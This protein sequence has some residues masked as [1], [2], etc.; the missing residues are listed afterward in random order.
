MVKRRQTSSTPTITLCKK[1]CLSDD[2]CQA[3]EPQEGLVN[4]SEEKI[5]DSE[6]DDYEDE[7]GDEDE[8]ED[9]NF[10]MDEELE[11]LKE[12]DPEAHAVLQ[13]VKVEIART[14]PDIYM[15]LKT[16]MRLE[17]RAKLCQFYEIYHMQV[18]NTNEWLEAR[19]RYNDMFKEYVAGYK[20][21]CKYS[22]EDIRRM[23]DE[24]KQFTGFDAQLALKYKILN[25]ETSK[26]NKEIIYRRYEELLSLSSTDDEYNKLKH[27][28]K[29]A[30][31][32]PHDRIRRLEIDNPT[33]FIQKAKQRLDTELYGMD[34]VKEQILLFLSGK[35]LNP[36]M[37]RSNL[38]LV[39][40][41]GCG[42]THIARLIASIM[43]WGF[44]QISLGGTDRAEFLKGHEYTYVGAQPG[45]IAKRM[46]E[47]GHKNGV[48]FFDEF[49]KIADSPEIRATML[50]LID[51]S[52]NKE[53][54]DNFLSP[55][56]IDLSHIWYVSSM[57]K[58]PDDAALADRWWVIQLQGYS[59]TD[60]V[61]IIEEYLIPRALKNA[62]LVDNSVA[63]SSRAAKHL[64]N[65]VCKPQD[66]G[67]RTL[68][69][70]IGDLI[71]KVS[72]IITHQ[73]TQGKLPFRTSFDIQSPLRFPVLLDE[74]LIDKL[75]ENVELTE[76]VQMMYI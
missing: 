15:L 46:K 35:I 22:K 30:T 51:P 72:F 9:G 14:E 58:I 2:D 65:G 26:E 17:D 66:K 6:S 61:H 48:I 64:I 36:S 50:H 45:E 55:L 69:N 7:E 43:D 23:E 70:H 5:E 20:Q 47:M 52:Q 57:N 32:I 63:L 19:N 75:V 42:K 28:L 37:R 71:N 12:R 68:E 4:S 24:E 33:F 13:D 74:A 56:T 31:S 21:H 18:P 38:A 11:K 67:V 25:L 29:W 16:P 10:N 76:A 27:W 62:G 39:G 60:K 1:R 53:F 3:T 73:D 59:Y 44:A 8:E 41:P 54:L 34:K 49:D 40:P